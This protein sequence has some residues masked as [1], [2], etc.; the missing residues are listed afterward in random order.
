MALEVLLEEGLKY[1][2]KEGIKQVAGKI[3]GG[4]FTF[5]T[6]LCK[7]ADKR[8]EEIRDHARQYFHCAHIE[9]C[10]ERFGN[11]PTS[12]MRD[13]VIGHQGMAFMFDG[14]PLSH[15]QADFDVK[16]LS[17]WVMRWNGTQLVLNGSGGMHLQPCLICSRKRKI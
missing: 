2:V 1:I 14:V 3:G 17:T 5:T 6:L 12:N 16:V 4:A 8:W 7:V 15:A 13:Y 11:T 9:I 10:P